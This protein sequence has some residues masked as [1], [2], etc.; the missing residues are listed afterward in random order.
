L[1]YYIFDRKLKLILSDI[2]ERIEVSIKANII[3][4]LS[5]EYN[6]SVFFLKKEIYLDKDK[7][8]S[9]KTSLES[10]KTKNKSLKNIELSQ[11]DSWKLFQ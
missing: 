1:K 2:I 9:I 4:T 3:N 5:L 6:D 10:E 7:F 8:N 11:I